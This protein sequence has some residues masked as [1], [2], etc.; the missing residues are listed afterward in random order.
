MSVTIKSRV[1]DESGMTRTL[2]RLTHEILESNRGTTDLALVGIHTRGAPLAER[3]AKR[4][5][6]L[7]GDH[8]PVG[9][10][11][12]TLHRDDYLTSG[13]MPKVGTTE[14]PFDMTDRNI[15][16]VDDVL[17]TGRTTRAAL[18]ALLA[19]GRPARI[20]M[21][22]L[23]DRGHREMPIQA[24]F[25]GKTIVTLPGEEVMVRLKEID[26]LDEVVVIETEGAA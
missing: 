6:Q 9:T 19:W 4:I 16:L 15:V 24:D 7:E 5:E 20:Q 26:G 17:Y 13:K 8:I 14:I 3:I 10:L 2:V 12:I 18:D 25:T 1:I 21:V 23:V 11:D 22:V